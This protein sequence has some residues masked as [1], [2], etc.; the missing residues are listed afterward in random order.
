MRKGKDLKAEW[1]AFVE[2]GSE[3][4]FY[5]LYDHYHDYLLYIGIQKEMPMEKV[6]DCINDLFLYVFEN[7][8]KLHT[9]NHHHNYLV[10]IFLRSL[11][12]KEHFSS[13]ESLTFDEEQT[14]DMPAYPSAEALYIQQNVQEQVAQTLKKYMDKLS[15]SQ[16]RMIYQK[17]YLGLTYEE[18]AQANGVSVKTVYNT[19]LQAVAKLKKLIGTQHIGTLAVTIS[20]LG[21]L[22]LFFFKIS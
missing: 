20:L 6:K 9:V 17:F 12:R 16:S 11:F 21:T 14:P 2:N 22:I 19:I 15:V 4:A 5:N 1:N 18:I 3:Q 10:T 13:S 8:L 7:R